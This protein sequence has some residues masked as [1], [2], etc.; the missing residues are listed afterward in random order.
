MKKQYVV[1]AALG[2][3]AVA[4]WQ[5][6]QR[7]SFSNTTIPLQRQTTVAVE[8]TS[9]RKDT[10]SEV[11]VFSGTLLPI[12]QFVVAPKIQGRLQKIFVNIGDAVKRDQLIAVLDD[13][14]YIQQVDQAAA[15][16]DV[17]KANVEENRSS[18]NLAEKEF[19]R[20]KALREKKIVSESELDAAEAQYMTAQAKRKVAEAQV[21]QKEAALQSA[22]V[23]LDY[24]Q[25]KASWENGSGIRVVG[26]R[27]VDE[28]SMLAANAPI[29]TV[30]D[31][32]A[33]TAVMH[34]IERDYPRIKIG[35]PAVIATDAYPER[36]FAGTIV[37]I[38]PI[39]KEEARQA[40]V[41]VAIPNRD[42]LLKPGMFVRVEIEFDRHDN[43]T[44]VPVSVLTK[45]NGQQS[46]FL[47]DRQTLTAKRVP[48]TVGIIHG[49]MAE[50]LNPPVSGLVVT[51]GQ[52]LLADGGAVTLPAA[53][54]PPEPGK[55]SD[56]PVL[57]KKQS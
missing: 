6:Y 8:V 49:D 41:E 33:L 32:H 50:I 54:M 45:H 40:R 39:L 53:A 24:S 9:V 43:A 44:V 13:A 52:H 27:F 5:I 2:L 56:E 26:E 47:V 28:G 31:I 1:V 19:E 51:V 11:G 25:I 36:K 29:A 42:M 35:Q 10:I 57:Q 30:I 38:A 55:S 16:L 12:S 14:E 21:A 46:I 4:G 15:E 3:A 7:N 20:A 18:L 34:V 48:V 22:R 37:R 17:A 23:R